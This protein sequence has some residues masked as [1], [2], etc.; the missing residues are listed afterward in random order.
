MPTTR[1]E[2]LQSSS[3]VVVGLGA[4]T[5]MGAGIATASGHSSE[6][7]PAH[8][9]SPKTTAPKRIL[10]LGGTGYLGPHTVRAALANGHEVTL[11]NRGKTNTHLFP[12]LEKLR[13]NR[14]TGDLDAL[15]GREWDAVI[16]TSGYL[17]RN[18]TSTAE[19][20]ADAVGQY[21]F[22]STISVYAGRSVPG[23]D[24][25]APLGQITDDEVQAVA[26]VRDMGPA[27]YGP[28]KARCEAAAEA[29]MPG[30]VTNIRPGLIVG[31]GDPTG[32]FTYWPVRVARGGEVLA[33]GTG[34]DYVQF[35]DVRDLARFIVTT[36][37]NNH[38]GIYNAQGPQ[39]LLTIEQLLHGCKCVSGSDAS[40]VWADADFLAD[41]GIHPWVQMPVWIPPDD[42][43]EGAGQMSSARAHKVGLTHNPPADT[44]KATLDWYNNLPKDSRQRSFGNNGVKPER[45]REVI[46]AWKTRDK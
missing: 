45:E 33:P 38:V 20:L 23:A 22:I 30:R 5:G 6:I 32:R 21:I 7:D 26:Q 15:K 41:Q 16:D 35:I 13:G 34:D 29:A 37:E 40:F 3:A 46:Q 19:F 10:F 31:P 36:I 24:E 14:R 44:I 28:L 8:T 12:D 27:Q 4:G 25:S 11:F 17:P 9:D 42:G 18:V 2:F 43:Y 1:R 39:H